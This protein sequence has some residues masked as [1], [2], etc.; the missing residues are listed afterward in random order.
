L[1]QCWFPDR[2]AISNTKNINVNIQ[3][4]IPKEILS[5]RTRKLLWFEINKM[6][7]AVLK[8][9]LLCHLLQFSR[10]RSIMTLKAKGKTTTTTTTV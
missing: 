7:I 3:K 9:N 8:I 10:P 5:N 4:N 2:L 6:L 1:A